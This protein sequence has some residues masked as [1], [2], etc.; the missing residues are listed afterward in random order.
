MQSSDD[1]ADVIAF[2][3]RPETWQTSEPVER[4]D[5]HAAIVFLA[6]DKAFKLKRAV[7]LGYLDF[8][9]PEKRKSVCE[10]EFRLN[11]LTAPDLYLGVMSVNRQ[12]DGSLGFGAGEPVD[13]LVAMRRF[14]PGDLLLAVAERGEL[15]PERVQELAD[16]IARFHDGAEVATGKDGAQRVRRVIEG[17]AR[18]MAALD[19]GALPQADCARL[20][21][22]CVT[23]ADR[24]AALLDQRAAQGHV[25]RSH[26]DLHLANICLWQGRP[27]LFDCL[28]FDEEL[29]TTDVLYDLA[30][31]LMDLWERGFRA[32][33]NLAFNRYLDMR[34][35]TGGIAAMPLFLAMRAAVRAHVAATA[36]AVQGDAVARMIK[37]NEARQYL[38]A[39]LSFLE[40]APPRLIAIG[41]LSGSGNSTLARALAP[42]I[43][44]APGARWLRTDVL[45]K[46]LGGVTPEAK[47]PPEA[48]TKERNAETYGQ[49]MKQVGD[50]LAAGRSVAVDGVFARPDERERIEAVA[51]SAG[52]EFTGLWLDA[53][54]DALLARIDRRRG[55]ASDADADVVRR[56][57]GYAL[58]ELSPWHR[59]DA[60]GS[61][62][63]TLD[64][65]MTIV[66]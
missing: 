57:L 65:A 64:A 21:E 30:F 28:E 19:P 58:G 56:Q 49:L 24:L 8:A 34:E 54:Q 9:S 10:A 27:T 44:N 36:S 17:N 51:R 45:R 61:A 63:Q 23:E 62:A 32:E 20:T 43:G 13:W 59:L 48:Y 29:A 40:A 26:G 15:T 11:K 18:S 46:R 31:L 47:L 22:A 16:H 33:A 53:P 14:P 60:S 6:R 4:I 37:L 7:D 2:L 41:G 3:S 50:C 42:L 38:A 52:V 5:T 12:P 55:D 1:Q 66:S 25:R 35:E 39:A